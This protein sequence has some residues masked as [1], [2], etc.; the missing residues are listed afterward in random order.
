MKP[1]DP[2]PRLLHA[3]F[4]EWMVQQRNASAHTVRSYRDTWRL[5]LRFVAQRRRRPIAQLALGDLTA[6]EVKTFLQYTEQE[7][8]DTIGTRNC[9]L[10]ALRSFFSFVADREPTAIEQCTQIL[11]VPMKK[12]PIHAP[13]YL[14][15]EEVKAILAQPDR[16]TIEG[17]RDHALFCFLYNTGARIQE[18]LDVCPRAIRFDSPTCVR[19]YGKG[20]KERL[21]P[22][23]PETV[24]LL[25]SQLMRQPRADDELIFVNRYGVPLG[26]SG[27]RFKLAQYVE[28]AA[29]IMPSLASKHVTP[30]SF[31]HATA[32]H[33]VAAG[34]DVTVIR[35]WL[36]HVSLDTTNHYAQ[37]NLETKRL[38]L[39]RLESPSRSAKRPSWKQDQSVLAWLDTL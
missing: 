21:S 28:A 17:Q 39:E 36:G 15:P 31:R 14:E 9:R 32:V 20:R 27:V 33:L 25:R 22:L 16:S 29:K 7:R 34:V 37:A 3:F 6:S 4:Y 19:L 8:G 26:A 13:C 24:S 23:W 12:A 5:F 35:S 38:A 10:S 1:V 11:H 30:H 2:F 18:A